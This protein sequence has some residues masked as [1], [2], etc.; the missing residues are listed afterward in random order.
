M[1]NCLSMDLRVRFKHLMDTGLCA[2]VAGRVLLLSRATAARWGKKVRNGEPLEPLP[3]GARKGSGKLEPFVPF[4]AELIAQDADITL[5][6]L[7]A[8]L[9][10]AYGVQ[11]SSGGL[12]RCLHRHGY[13]YKKGRIAQERG[14]ACVQRSRR[15][16][17]EKR[18]PLMRDT[19]SRLVFIDETAVKT[20]L[21]RSHG[22][23]PVGQR[24]YG[25]VP[26]GGW[27]TQ[28][29]IA[30]LMDQALIAPWVLNAPM[31]R[32]A[33]DTCIETQLAPLL[34][35]RSIVI[36]DNLA[37]HKSPRAAEVLAERK[38]WM[39]F[40]PPYSPDLNPI[41]MAFSKLKAHLRKIGAR[42]YEAL[43]KAIGDICNLF[44]EEE[45]WNYFRAC[46]YAP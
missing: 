34:P 28:T 33:F 19:P 12:H 5:R 27:Q 21:T 29:F 22:R 18:Q 7:E 37:T 14:R 42:S 2:A 38:C 36:L 45:C 41:E 3:S 15:D 30:G 46:G 4:F 43:I 11:C 20:T 40:L 8:A 24:L 31:N 6:E 32:A 39:L 16:W 13:R 9:L 17:T 23:A 44:T 26:F 25:Q 10:D 1:S 35:E